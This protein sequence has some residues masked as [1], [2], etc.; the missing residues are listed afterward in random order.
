MNVGKICE[1]PAV[2]IGVGA[3][4]VDAAE[5][6]CAEGVGTLVVTRRVAERRFV[7]GILTDRDILRAQLQGTGDLSQLS[8]E[9]AMTRDPLLVSTDEEVVDVV[10]KLLA[11]GVRRAPLVDELG[12]PRSVLSI[13][14]LL[15]HLARQLGAMAAVVG[16]QSPCGRAGE[17]LISDKQRDTAS[18]S[19]SS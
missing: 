11:R 9:D 15:Q 5:R 6:M 7:V 13:D 8:I 17:Q 14:D 1:H 19:A 12:E 4:L 2:C 18:A 3:S 16:A 10:S